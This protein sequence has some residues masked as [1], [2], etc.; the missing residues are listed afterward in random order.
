MLRCA[1]HPTETTE[2]QAAKDF[3]AVPEGGCKKPCETRLDCGHVC[4]MVCHPRDSEHVNVKCKKQCTKIICDLYHKCS[5]L[6][7]QPCDKKCNYKINKLLDCGHT[8]EI[9]CHEESSHNIQCLEKCRKLLRCGHQCKTKC[10]EECTD[11]CKEMVVKRFKCGH[12]G[13]AECGNKDENCPEPCDKKPCETRLDCG[14]VCPMVCH[15]RDSE[16]VNVKCK[17]QC[18]KI[19]CDLYH[20]CSRLCYQPCDKK[21]NYKINKLLDC[22]HTKEIHCHEE[23]SHNITVLREMSKVTQMRHQCKTKC[24]EECTDVC[25]EMVVKRFKCGHKGKAECG[26]KDENCPEPC[27]KKPCETRLDCG[28]VCPMRYANGDARIVNVA[29]HAEPCKRLPVMNHVERYYLEHECIGVCGE[30]CPKLCRI[31]D[32]DEVTEVLFGNEDEDDAR[33]GSFRHV[34]EQTTV[35]EDTTVQLR[36]CPKCKTPIRRNLRYGN[37]IKQV[38]ADVEEIKKQILGDP[39]NIKEKR[40]ELIQ[41]LSLERD[42]TVSEIRRVP[43]VIVFSRATCVKL[44]FYLLCFEGVCG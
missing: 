41:D 11:V 12:K 34:D 23:S 8:K 7:Y 29:D 40:E 19:I 3:K 5:R 25:K 38:R 36:V 14:H 30:T 28:H 6:C 16:H 35:D 4:P 9:H 33:S 2:V 43:L 32:K 37:V 39:A 21:C 18:T 22:G 42:G 1:N 44:C 20:K 24:S 31:C 15:P 17:K 26:N 10:S 13:K 27:D